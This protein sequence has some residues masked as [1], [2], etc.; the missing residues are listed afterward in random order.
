MILNFMQKPAFLDRLDKRW[1]S[2]ISVHI[3]CDGDAGDDLFHW[4]VEGVVLIVNYF[5]LFL[6]I[7]LISFHLSI[8]NS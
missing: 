2:Y 7:D 8:M 1:Y 5:Y 6:P 4:G 3:Q